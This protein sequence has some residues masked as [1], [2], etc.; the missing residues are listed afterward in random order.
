MDDLGRVVEL[1]CPT[2][3]DELKFF[4]FW[5]YRDLHDR[6]VTDHASP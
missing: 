2:N 1:L 5:K 6:P 4:D 3:N